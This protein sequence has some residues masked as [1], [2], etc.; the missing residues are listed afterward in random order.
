[1]NAVL[2][3]SFLV[4][5]ADKVPAANDVKAGWGAFWIFVLMAVAVALL[6]VSL[7][8]HLR[9]A[10]ANAEAGAFAPSDEPRRPRS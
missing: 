1:M 2:L 3:A 5:Y 9:K 6:G 7:T 4:P 8:R 10:R